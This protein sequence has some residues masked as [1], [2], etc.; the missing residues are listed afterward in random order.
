MNIIVV[1]CLVFPNILNPKRTQREVMMVIFT[2]QSHC[3]SWSE[4]SMFST[5]W[6]L[7]ISLYIT[8]EEIR[9]VLGTNG[10]FSFGIQGI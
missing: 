3:Q 7:N 4:L 2:I 8:R 1:I 10:D 6:V 5:T 9:G